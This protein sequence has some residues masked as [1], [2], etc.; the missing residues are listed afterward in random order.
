MIPQNL[1][2]NQSNNFVNFGGCINNPTINYNNNN[3]F[4][5][6]NNDLI[7]Q[8]FPKTIY[9]MMNNNLMFPLINFNFVN[10][11]PMQNNQNMFNSQIQNFFNNN[12]TEIVL[13]FRFMTNPISFKVKTRQTEKLIDIIERFKQ[14]ECPKELIDYLSV[15]A[16]NGNRA[17]KNKTLFELGI[18]NGDNILFMDKFTGNDQ[19]VYTASKNNEYVLT[20]KEKVQYNRLK[21][22]YETRLMI[23][24]AFKNKFVSQTAAGN[25]NNS[26]NNIDEPIQSF[27]DFMKE[28][29]NGLGIIASEH[30]HILVYCLTINDWKCNICNE[31]NTKDRG[32]Y[33]CSLCDYNMCEKCHEKKKYFM[34]KS[35]PKGTKPSNTRIHEQFLN[36]DYHEHRL[37][38]CRS[39]RKFDFFN[40]YKCS[41][42]LES[43]DNDIWL[44]Y[45]TLCDYNLCLKCC[46][47]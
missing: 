41:N 27:S 44:F 43:Y 26:I 42:C 29:D 12:N 19:T 35:F 40:G 9:P 15:C 7:A 2:M 1:F 25:N 24:S 39:S 14:N 47:Y 13:N 6:N 32:R 20:E 8:P 28:I 36:T 30:K 22:Q 17:D 34:K 16:C 46:G 23:K 4:N 10:P 37:V 31:N 45:C 33:Y 38:F 21:S 3:N 18:N 11:N 5:Y